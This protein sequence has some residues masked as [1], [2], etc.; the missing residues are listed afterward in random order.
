MHQPI[1]TAQDFVIG[2][3]QTLPNQPLTKAA[4]ALYQHATPAQQSAW[5]TAYEKA[6]ANA[7][8]VNGR[9]HVPPGLT[10]RSASW[11]AP[12]PP[13]PRPVASTARC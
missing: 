1:D 6:V 3:L 12:S 9:L 13:W 2:P 5:T 4:I 7:T 10:G 11:W 8:E